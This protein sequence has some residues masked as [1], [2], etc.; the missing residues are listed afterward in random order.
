MSCAARRSMREPSPSYARMST[1]IVNVP[2]DDEG[3]V[4]DVDTPSD[5]EACAAEVIC[6][7]ERRFRRKRIPVSSVSLRYR[8][9]PT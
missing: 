6:Q 5:Y 9:F 8:K 7:S 2:V 3:C 4:R 1:E